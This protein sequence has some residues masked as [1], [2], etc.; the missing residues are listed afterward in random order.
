MT[1]KVLTPSEAVKIF[2]A[3]PAECLL[4]SHLLAVHILRHWVDFGKFKGQ[5]FY[6]NIEGVI[7]F[8][9]TEK[10][11]GEFVID[12]WVKYALLKELDIE[13]RRWIMT[14]EF[15]HY[16]GC[17]G[18]DV[19]NCGAC[20][21]TDIRQDSPNYAGWPLSYIENGR[22]IPVKWFD[23]FLSELASDN[24]AYAMNLRE[25]MTKHGVKFG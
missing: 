20:A 24:T 13:K 9:N 12:S 21:L 11:L 14:R 22:T 10:L 25:K 2:D 1:R 4:G 3:I 7:Q 8:L 15:E 18:K 5:P 16:D 23:A 6:K 19:D 17:N